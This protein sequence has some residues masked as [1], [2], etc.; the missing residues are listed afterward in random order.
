MHAADGCSNVINGSTQYTP[1]MGRKLTKPRGQHGEKLA[2]L[3]RDAG[4]TQAELAEAIG[5]HQQT[6]A[7]WERSPRPARSDAIPKL[8]R[9]LGVSVEDLL[10]DANV[11]AKQPRKSGPTGKI[12]K[13]FDEVSRL[14]RRQQDKIAE[15][16]SAFIEQHKRKAS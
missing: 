10:N 6:I 3:R 5:E 9:I 4:L 2:A 14:P 13:L 16:V 11:P 7:Y 1:R 8:A 12:D 15:F